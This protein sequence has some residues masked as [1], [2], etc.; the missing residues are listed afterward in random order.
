MRA[1]PP[2]SEI[3]TWAAAALA[4]GLGLGGGWARP[5]NADRVAHFLERLEGAGFKQRFQAAYVL[6][7]LR[8]PRAVP[9][10]V[11]RLGDPH[12][13]VRA[14][15]AAALGKLG[16]P[17]SAPAL[18]S[19]LGDADAWVRAEAVKALGVVGGR[20]AWTRLVAALGDKD[21]RVRLEAIRALGALGERGAVMPLARVVEE[22]E[23]D[24]ELAAEARR[25]LQR[26]APAIDVEEVV[27]RIKS[28]TSKRE[29]AQAVVVLAEL[30]DWRVLPTLIEALADP[31]PYVRAR[32]VLGLARSTDRRAAEA[33]GALLLREKD[34]RVRG[35]A[36]PTLA[37]LRRALGP[38]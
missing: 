3:I 19:C 28:A 4:L 23:E 36:E 1:K 11:K 37:K 7:I 24:D 6:G 16:G 29:R 34:A 35:V 33:I 10:L 31:E 25:A 15:A 22:G 26:L 21:F 8:D 32:A 30:R 5:A 20:E 13:A 18:L 27:F 14:A 17:L 2:L 12:Y 9:H 38:P